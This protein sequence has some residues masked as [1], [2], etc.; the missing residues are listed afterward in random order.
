MGDMLDEI[1]KAKQMARFSL[2]ANAP[3]G[4]VATSKMDAEPV[5]VSE[6]SVGK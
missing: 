5:A 2:N 6:D 4:E 1:T 3:N